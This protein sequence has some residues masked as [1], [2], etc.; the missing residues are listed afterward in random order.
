MCA[1]SQTLRYDDPDAEH[2]ADYDGPP[3]EQ[4]A[5]SRRFQK[6]F[7]TTQ[8]GQALLALAT[9][10]DPSADVEPHEVFIGGYAVQDTTTTEIDRGPLGHAALREALVRNFEILWEQKK[11]QWL[12]YPKKK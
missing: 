9:G 1:L 12:K 10:G 4:R 6:R 11:V 7:M 3:I 2:R 8:D 5:Q